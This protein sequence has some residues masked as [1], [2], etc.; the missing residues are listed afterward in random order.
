VCV[1]RAME[2][3]L[4]NKLEGSKFD[5]ADSIKDMVKA[6]E[7]W[8]RRQMS[9]YIHQPNSCDRVNACLTEHKKLSLSDLAEIVIW[10]AI[11]ESSGA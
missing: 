7:E 8:V 5:D 9:I 10:I 6:F 11:M 4:Q 3:L 1:D 2:K